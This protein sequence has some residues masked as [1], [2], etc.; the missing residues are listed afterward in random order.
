MK[1]RKALWQTKCFDDLGLGRTPLPSPPASFH[2]VIHP[3]MSK[4]ESST[5]QPTKEDAIGLGVLEEDDEFEEFPV[6]GECI[7]SFH[8][9]SKSYASS[10]LDLCIQTGTIHR[11]ISQT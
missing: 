1:N 3:A 6:Q 9:R 11:R 7:L 4:A 10:Q 5:N 8:P 2:P